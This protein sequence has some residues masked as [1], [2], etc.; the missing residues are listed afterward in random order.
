MSVAE[1]AVVDYVIGSAEGGV[2]DPGLSDRIAEN[3]GL[4]VA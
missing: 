1:G 2:V 3:Y 4:M